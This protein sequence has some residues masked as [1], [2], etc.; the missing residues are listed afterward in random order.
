[1]PLFGTLPTEAALVGAPTMTGFAPDTWK[2]TGVDLLQVSYEVDEAPALAVTP[3]ALHPSIPPYATFTVAEIAD[4]PHGPFRLAMVRLIVRA[5]IRPRALLLGAWTSSADVADGLRSGWG[6]RIDV[7]DIGFSRRYGAI[8]GTVTIG[9]ITALDVSVEDPEPI[10]GADI[11]LFDNLHLTNVEG[12]DPVI[13]Q[14]DPTYEYSA[15]DRGEAEL[16]TFEPD[17]LGIDGV[18]PVYAVVGVGCRA[19]ME[20]A[21]PRFVMDPDKPAIQSTRRL[22]RAD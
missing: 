13:V 4:S 16:T 7:A 21:A 3:P 18:V 9:G 10:A 1:M 6:Y 19:D 8:R 11:E 2:L 22:E 5:G 20:L 14:V 12:G 17:V 15:A